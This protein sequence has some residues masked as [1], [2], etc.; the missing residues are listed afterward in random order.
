MPYFYKP[1]DPRDERAPGFSRMWYPAGGDNLERK[2]QACGLLT[3]IPQ[4]ADVYDETG[5]LIQK[6][7]AAPAATAARKGE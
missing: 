2:A 3:Q 1:L 4:N 5:A 7:P 6:G